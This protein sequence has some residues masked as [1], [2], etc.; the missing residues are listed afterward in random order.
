MIHRAAIVVPCYNEAHRLPGDAFLAFLA[1]HPGVRF[2]FVDDGSTDQTLELLGHLASQHPAISVVPSPRNQGKAEAVRR[3]FLHVLESNSPAVGFW[4]ADLATPLDAIP[5]FLA[6]LETRPSL[7]MVFGARVQLLGRSIRRKPVRHYLGRVFATQ[8][9]IMLGLPIY[10]TQCGAKIFRP[11]PDLR[12]VF[13][14]PFLTNWTFDVEILAR[15]LRLRSSSQLASSIYEFP[16]DEWRDVDG[17][18]VR[19]R[20]FLI[21]LRDLWRIYFRYLR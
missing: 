16:L 15:F 4:D 18:K 12:A 11:N 5:A 17:S 9:S 3:G 21:A 7:D 8:A 6:M 20:D 19:P 1:V 14:E 2:V 10:D 13:A